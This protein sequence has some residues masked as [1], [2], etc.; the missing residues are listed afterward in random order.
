[1][2]AEHPAE[3]YF[4]KDKILD[5]IRELNNYDKNRL[6]FLY[7]KYEFYEYNKKYNLNIQYNN[8]NK[9]LNYLLRI[10]DEYYVVM[11]QIF[12]DSEMKKL[13]K[14]CKCYYCEL[15]FWHW[16]P[17]YI[18]HILMKYCKKPCH[19]R[20]LNYCFR[21]FDEELN[22]Y[23]NIPDPYILNKTIKNL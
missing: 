11:L 1:M 14:N 18:I 9:Y 8:N 5:P 22:L 23:I 4:H 16:N 17:I 13:I 10:G 15:P 21:Y 20:C 3:N 2:E 19:E 6:L 7:Y 12:F